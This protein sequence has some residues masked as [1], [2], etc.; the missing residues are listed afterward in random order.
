[1]LWSGSSE[2]V[3]RRMPKLFCWEEKKKLLTL[4]YTLHYIH[5][6]ISRFISKKLQKYPPILSRHPAIFPL[7]S[8]TRSPELD[9]SRTGQPWSADP[10]PASSRIPPRPGTSAWVS[11]RLA[12]TTPQQAVQRTE[13]CVA[14]QV[15]LQVALLA[16]TSVSGR[17]SS[18]NN[19]RR[20]RD[21]LHA[22]WVPSC[23]LPSLA[24]QF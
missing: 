15:A 21:R 7:I 13:A 6:L 16:N 9:S 23:M 1:M 5:F 10:L 22:R 11:G 18:S 8:F 19:R 12:S 17:S 20:V 3:G 14:P 2:G 4:H 24:L